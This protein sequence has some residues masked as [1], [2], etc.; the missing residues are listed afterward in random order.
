MH[1]VPRP[2]TCPPPLATSLATPLAIKF[3]TPRRSHGV[4]AGFTLVEL[5]IVVTLIGI[6]TAIAIPRIWRLLDSIAVTGAINDIDALLVRTRH[7][8]MMRGERATL[9]V[10]TARATVILRVGR[11][12]LAR[13]EEGSLTGVRLGA[14][15]TSVT[16]T[17]LGLGL[18]VSN[19]TLVATR[20]AAVETLTVSRLGRV[21][22]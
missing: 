4:R 17:Q 13:R 11:D 3:A 19:L 12:T 8:A 18:G 2:A 14:T 9:E 16:Y 5:I 6:L 10:D 1:P 15:R 20:G 7:T 22:W 21:R